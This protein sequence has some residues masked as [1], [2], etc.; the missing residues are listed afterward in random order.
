MGLKILLIVILEMLKIFNFYK[1]SFY[2]NL[3]GGFFVNFFLLL[4]L[5]L[6]KF[7]FKFIYGEFLQS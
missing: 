4:P 7:E 3:R 2:F 1:S 6:E 5:I